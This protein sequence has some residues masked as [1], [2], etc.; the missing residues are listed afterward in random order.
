[1]G[2]RI[3]T[4]E[5]GRE[6]GDRC[7]RC[8]A[9]HVP[10]AIE[11]GGQLATAQVTRFPDATQIILILD[12]GHKLCSLLGQRW[13]ARTCLRVA[14]CERLPVARLPG[15]LEDPVL[16]LPVHFLSLGPGAEILHQGHPQLPS[17]RAARAQYTEP[18]GA[19]AASPVV[20]SD[21]GCKTLCTA[22]HWHLDHTVCLHIQ[23]VVERATVEHQF[24]VEAALE[25]DVFLAAAEQHADPSGLG[26]PFRGPI[27][28]FDTGICPIRN[29]PAHIGYTGYHEKELRRSLQRD[30]D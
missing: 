15:E 30:P 12:G 2:G 16:A 9:V 3:L 24:L 22:L 17:G 10:R 25:R 1:M 14:L 29:G 20:D 27:R 6:I 8:G 28:L 13:Y 21:A 26:H 5:I 11:R 7:R 18:H 19:V 4:R 23:S